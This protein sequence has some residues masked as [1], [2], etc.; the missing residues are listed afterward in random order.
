M[1]VVG[2]V[3]Y[4]TVYQIHIRAKHETNIF[5]VS[6]VVDVLEHVHIKKIVN[7]KQSKSYVEDVRSATPIF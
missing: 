6:N 1:F 5:T 2:N 4:K 7:K 3:I